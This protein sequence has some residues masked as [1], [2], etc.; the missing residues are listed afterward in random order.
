MQDCGV[1]GPPAE[2]VAEQSQLASAGGRLHSCMA[3]R[4]IPGSML[5]QIVARFKWMRRAVEH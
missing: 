4:P 5:C 3:L 1:Q 2:K